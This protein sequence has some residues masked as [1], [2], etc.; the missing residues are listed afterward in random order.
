MGPTE[1][2][3]IKERLLPPISP[4]K[5]PTRALVTQEEKHRAYHSA[6]H[7]ATLF[8]SFLL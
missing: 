1:K 8:P 3:R 5:I 7:R 4:P 6:L 2:T